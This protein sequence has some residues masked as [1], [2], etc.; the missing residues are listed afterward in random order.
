LEQGKT[1]YWRVDENVIGGTVAG[2]VWSFTVRPVIAKADLSLVGWWKMD[3][4]KA[5]VAVDYSGYDN[6]GTL[7]G[8]PRFVEGYLGDALSFDGL[9]DHVNCGVRDSLNKVDSVS[10]SAWVRLN[11]VGAD[12]KIASNQSGAGYKMGVYTN[13]MVE[14]EIRTAANAAI[15]NRTSP[16]GTALAANVWYHIV[17][18]YDKGK[19]IRTYINGKLDR[20]M[21][22]A[23]VAGVS[24][25]AF[26]LGREAP[27]GAYWF[28]GLMDDVRVY[29]KALTD[30]Q[31]QKVMQG[32]VRLAWDPQPATGATLDIRDAASLKWS[33]GEGATKRNVYLG[34][35]RDAVKAADTT[36]PLY[37]DQQTAT[38]FSLAGKVEFG[39]GSYFWRIDEVAADGTTVHKGIVWT[40]TIPGYLIV[41]EFENYTDEEGSRIYETWIDGWTNNTGSTVGNLVAPF[42][43]RTI[44]HS[45]KQAM[46]LDFNNTKSPFYSEAEVTF[47]PLQDWTGYGVTDLSLWFRG[48]PVSYMDKGNGAFTVGAS[49]HDIWDAADD[50]RFVYKRL[51]GNGSVTVKVD[52]LVNTNVWAKAGV[53]IRESLTD[54]SPMAYMI[55]SYSSGVSFGW[56]LTANANAA[57]IPATAGINAPQWVKLTR[58]GN[59]FTAQYSANGTTWT[60]IKNTDGTVTSTT[61]NMA[62]TVYIGLCVTSHNTAAT[63]TAQ[64]SGAATTG[65][66]TGAW[67]PVWIG[68]D[69]DLTN[70][71]AGLY[72]AVEDS[73]GKSI[74]LTHPD[75]TA[76]NVSAWTEWKI[77]LNSLTGV[78][79][80]RVKKLSLGV[81]DKKAPA[82]GGSGRVYIDDIR[83]IKP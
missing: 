68:D 7:V 46:P 30:A 59:A 25:G 81:G 49:G 27:A 78:N 19:A 14:F 32:D 39:G 64:F 74:T 16:G 29:N 58:T 66:V 45:G 53:M 55:Q 6:Y 33:A 20:E 62:G 12:R 56:R 67:Q 36:S 38:S 17:G 61:I 24:P 22:T 44:I 80:A 43:E 76:A 54:G 9:D 82:A 52:S 15:L 37:Q 21:L 63:T 10:V 77:P 73:T 11:V 72:L 70:G 75:P 40:F 65:G 60:D 50:F 18:V 69:P 79:L 35:D 5:G 28:N 71:A 8:G 23:E 31:I 41:D 26:M 34:K 13:N 2:P 42:A 83:V 1:Y 48:N 57:S 3:D 4:E 47:A 51:S